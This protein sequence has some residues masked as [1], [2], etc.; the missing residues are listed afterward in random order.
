MSQTDEIVSKLTDALTQY[1]PTNDG[2]HLP[3]W[4]GQPVNMDELA[5]WDD[6]LAAHKKRKIRPTA[7]RG[8]YIVFGK[9]SVSR[10]GPKKVPVPGLFI[11]NVSNCHRTTTKAEYYLKKGWKILDWFFPTDRDVPP[12]DRE[13]VNHLS[14]WQLR[15]LEDRD[16][17]YDLRNWCKAKHATHKGMNEFHIERDELQT[18]IAELE[19]KLKG[20]DGKKK[21][22][23]VRASD[24]AG[25][26]NTGTDSKSGT[27][28]GSGKNEA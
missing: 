16:P 10:G 26:D 11:L 9:V 3:D 24:G 27:S 8:A 23:P 12:L 13:A 22:E 25:K 14:G 6:L 20:K 18:R 2:S 17:Y 4:D 1:K 28:M 19:A 15:C 5:L 7:R 21:S